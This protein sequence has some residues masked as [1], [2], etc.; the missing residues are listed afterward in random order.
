MTVT[1]VNLVGE[2]G[3]NFELR[4]AAAFIT[5]IVPLTVFFSLQKHFVRGLLAGS[6]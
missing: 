5:M 1:L 4:F 3:S 6:V 2:R